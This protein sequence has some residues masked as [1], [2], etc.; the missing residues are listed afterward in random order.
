MNKDRLSKLFKNYCFIITVTV[1]LSFISAC[2]L[3]PQAGVLT[4]IPVCLICGMAAGLLKQ[5]WLLSAGIFAITDYLLISFYVADFEY[6]LISSVFSAVTALAGCLSVWLFKKKSVGNTVLSAFCLLAVCL[7]HFVVYGNPVSALKASSYI[8]SY[9][10]KSYTDSTVVNG[11][12]FDRQKR[13]FYTE[14]Y[15]KNDVTNVKTIYSDGEKVYDNYRNHAIISVMSNAR[16]K[17]QTTLRNAFPGGSFLVVSTNSSAFLND[18]IDV[19]AQLDD[20]QIPTMCFDIQVNSALD[21]D[22]FAAL[23]RGYF[24]TL[25]KAG[26]SPDILRVRGG[27]AGQFFFTATPLYSADEMPIKIAFE[28]DDPFAR[29]MF[30]KINNILIKG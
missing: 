4:T 27:N 14:V 10:E 24:N 1:I 30:S 15:G 8:D 17:L 19:S 7:C 28:P 9:I 2:A 26:I 25:A 22:S 18:K 3:L 16:L 6:A 12:R 29:Y 20:S 21:M 23:A 13:L 5:K 11:I